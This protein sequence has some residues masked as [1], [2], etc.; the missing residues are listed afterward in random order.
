MVGLCLVSGEWRGNGLPVSGEWSACVWC[1]VSG[2]G[3]VCLCLV[4]GRPVS[5]VW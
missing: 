3:M 2:E 5:G 1:L 4:S